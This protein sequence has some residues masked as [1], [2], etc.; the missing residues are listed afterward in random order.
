MHGQSFP[1][2]I[3]QSPSGK[4][5]HMTNYD[6]PRTSVTSLVHSDRKTI[7]A[8]GSIR[9]MTCFQIAVYALN[10]QRQQLQQ[11][12]WVILETLYPA[13]ARVAAAVR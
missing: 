9:G 8:Y 13:I 4:I 5:S 3:S 11:Q 12:W 2:D 7:A 1:Y 10:W 6:G